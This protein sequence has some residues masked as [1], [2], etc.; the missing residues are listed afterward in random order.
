VEPNVSHC[1]ETLADLLGAAAGG[2][3]AGLRRLAPVLAADLAATGVPLR[4]GGGAD[5][6]PTPASSSRQGLLQCLSRR[7]VAELELSPSVTSDAL[8]EFARLITAPGVP[9]AMMPS[10]WPAG[11]VVRGAPQLVGNEP[12]TTVP[13]CPRHDAE[14]GSALRSVFV[15]HRLIDRLPRLPG[16]APVACKVVVQAVVERLLSVTG[17]LEPL[18]LL[19]RDEERL[20]RGTRVAVLAVVLA[21][22]AGWPDDRLADLGAAALLH[23]LGSLLDEARPGPAAF[24]WLLERGADDLWLRC[25]LVSRHWRECQADADGL[26]GNELGAAV[27]VRLAV[28][29][30][31]E[32]GGAGIAARSGHGGVPRPELLQA[33]VDEALAPA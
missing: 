24:A 11:V 12:C 17:G 3:S 8:L 20:Q 30:E 16:I 29:V 33:I 22:V 4:C 2:D 26:G 14:P 6:A 5:P 1:L 9:G 25:A 13:F 19:E 7:G 10:A 32:L 23:D 15:Q 28:E 18:M 21:R 27:L 31:R